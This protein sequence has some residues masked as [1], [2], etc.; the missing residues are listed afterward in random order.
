[1]LE[2]AFVRIKTASQLD[3]T[4]LS[5]PVAGEEHNIF[6][7]LGPAALAGWLE[8]ASC[9]KISIV[10]LLFWTS[11]CRNI[12]NIRKNRGVKYVF[13]AIELP[14]LPLCTN[15]KYTPVVARISLLGR[16]PR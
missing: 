6:I 12:E 3:D 1:M 8:I 9:D 16:G 2:Y 11:L 10:A 5:N 15:I 13:P 7:N 4:E 14:L